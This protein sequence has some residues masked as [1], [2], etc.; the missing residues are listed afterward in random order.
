MTQGEAS[1]LLELAEAV[2]LT[3]SHATATGGMG[4]TRSLSSLTFSAYLLARYAVLRPLL[5]E[6]GRGLPVWD[7]RGAA[8]YARLLTDYRA[9]KKQ[10]AG[11]RYASAI[12][13]LAQGGSSSSSGGPGTSRAVEA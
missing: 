3:A 13:A 5:L 11:P 6:G 2:A 1:R 4:S 9:V 7:S 8:V 10:L 12:E